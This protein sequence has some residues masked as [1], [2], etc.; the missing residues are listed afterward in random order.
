MADARTP[1]ETDRPVWRGRFDY[2]AATNVLDDN[3]N[4]NSCVGGGKAAKF[5]LQLSRQQKVSHYLPRS[6]L[7]SRNIYYTSYSNNV[8]ITV[9]I[10]R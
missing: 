7:R 6:P 2:T 4:N 9:T 8:R 5:R 1:V 10:G 3:D